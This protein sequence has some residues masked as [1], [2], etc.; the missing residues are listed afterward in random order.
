MS[1]TIKVGS[2][3]FFGG[4][5]GYRIKDVDEIAIQDKWLP[6]G[7]NVLNFKKGKKD[8]FLWS[9]LSKKQF[10]EDAVTCGV[11]MRVGKFIVPEFCK[12]IGFEVGDYRLLYD[13]F[14]RLDER[15][16]YEKVIMESYVKNGS[17][18]L[19]DRQ[20]EAA[21]EIYKKARGIN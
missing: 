20:R 15:H 7:I 17:F 13:V 21:Y 5:E 8:V 3:V 10:I 19:T 12:H 11:P 18:V 1:K 4:M 16:A 2:S 14:D 6:N 9:P